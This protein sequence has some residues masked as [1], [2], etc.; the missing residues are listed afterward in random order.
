MDALLRDAIGAA[1]SDAYYRERKHGT[2]DTARVAAS[3]A[4]EAVLREPGHAVA[5]MQLLGDVREGW[6]D[7]VRFKLADDMVVV[8]DEPETSHSDVPVFVV[9][10]RGEETDA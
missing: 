10:P 7:E 3:L 9:R 1:I 2:M 5:V 4:V 6:V 8:T